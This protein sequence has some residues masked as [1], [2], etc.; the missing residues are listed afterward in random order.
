MANASVKCPQ[1]GHE[2]SA[3]WRWTTRD[4]VLYVVAVG[5]IGLMAL[6]LTA[7]AVVAVLQLLGVVSR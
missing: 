7:M 1:C 6:A 2:F 3:E 4:W 5:P